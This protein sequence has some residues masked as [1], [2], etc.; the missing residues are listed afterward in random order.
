MNSPRVVHD[1]CASGLMPGAE[2]RM[3]QVSHVE[4][5]KPSASGSPSRPRT[6]T[7]QLL[8]HFSFLTLRP[9]THTS[10]R[11]LPSPLRP[12]TTHL[13]SLF[14]LSSLFAS[15]FLPPSTLV[16]SSFPRQRRGGPLFGRACTGKKYNGATSCEFLQAA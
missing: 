5:A 3:P 12:H 16:P 2:R 14:R 9:R 15:S 1:E 6:R 10:L 11:L 7:I 8:R 13:F 4:S